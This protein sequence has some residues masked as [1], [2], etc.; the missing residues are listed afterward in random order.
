MTLVKQINMP[1]R[2]QQNPVTKAKLI[3]A[4]WEMFAT[5]G[6][7]R[8]TV[9]A[10]IVS[11]GVSKGAFY[12]YFASKEDILD[13]VIEQTSRQTLDEI[14]PLA[15]DA[16]LPALDRLNRFLSAARNW[17]LAHLD[18][19]RDVAGVLYRDENII[20]RH[21]MYQRNVELALPLLAGI[22]AQGVQEGVFDTPDPEETA[23][24]LLYMGNVWG[25][26][27]A[28]ALGDLEQRP[29]NLDL[30]LRRMKLYVGVLE[31]ILG[32]PQGSIERPEPETMARLLGETHTRRPGEKR[33]D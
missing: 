15:E 22:L 23:R 5:Q 17:R 2:K 7:D 28:G 11:L 3:R 24:L 19:I 26:I 6:Y 20:I 30:I 18:L 21:K 4:A 10:I 16:T 1:R 29:E 27:Q 33:H 32:A 8:A 12:H 31:R 14:K 13:A 9:E 25:E